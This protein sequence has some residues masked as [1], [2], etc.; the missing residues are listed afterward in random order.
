MSNADLRAVRT[1][2]VSGTGMVGANPLVAAVSRLVP[3]S[4]IQFI[5]LVI[6]TASLSATAGKFIEEIDPEVGPL[7]IP[8][9]ERTDCN[10]VEWHPLTGE[11][12][13]PAQSLWIS[14]F[15][16]LEP[17]LGSWIPLPYLRFLGRGEDGEPRYDKGPSN[18]VRLYLERPPEGLRNVDALKAVVAIDTQVD[19]LSRIDQRNYLLPNSDD[20][21][22]APIFKLV[23]DAA[24]VDAF[25]G[26]D[27][28][29]AW[30]RRLYARAEEGGAKKTAATSDSAQTQPDFT[31]EHVARYLSMLKVLDNAVEMPQLQF[32]DARSTHW[33]TRSSSVDVLLDIDTSETSAAIIPSGEGQSDDPQQEP[34]TLRFRDLSHPTRAHEGSFPT[35]A[36]FCAPDFG[37]EHASLRSGRPD[38]FYWPSL[39]RV[40]AEGLRL[41]H[42][43]GAVPGQTGLAGLIGSLGDTKAHG[44]T[45]RFSAAGAANKFEEPGTMVAG[46]L[47]SHVAED[48]RIITDGAEDLE[49][50]LR[51][52]FSLSAILSMFIAECILH[53]MAQI[54]DC[55]RISTS[56][57]L[58]TLKRVLITCQLSASSEERKQL[59]ARVEQA[60]DQIWT[61]LGWNSDE[62][63]TPNR[64]EVVLSM[65]SDLSSQIVYLHDE[66]Q[67]CYCG[68]VRQFVSLVGRSGLDKRNGGPP[69]LRVATLDLAS[70]ATTLCIIDY[71]M[72]KEGG[73]TPSIEVAD[74]TT[75]AGDSLIEMVVNAHILPAIASALDVAGHAD[76]AALL[77]RAIDASQNDKA[78]L[79]RHF[80]ARF[81]RQVLI[82]AA[83]ALIELHQTVSGR[84]QSAIVRRVSFSHLVRLGGGCMAPL[85]AKLEALAAGENARQFRLADV[86]IAYDAQ[87][88]SRTISQHFSEPVT[89]ASEACHAL[90]ADLML[91]SGRY[92]DLAE[93]SSLIETILPLSPHRIVNM[94][95]H[96]A[97]SGTLA[98]GLVGADPRLAILVGAATCNRGL[99]APLDRIAV[100]AEDLRLASPPPPASAWL[101]GRSADK[102]T[103]SGVGQ[104]KPKMNRAIAHDAAAAAAAA[105]TAT[106]SS[107]AEGAA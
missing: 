92:A 71:S 1:N 53:A 7:L 16:A 70:R 11:P 80:S 49:P 43:S 56:G 102:S 63:L 69:G 107:R 19:T 38:A 32:V 98:S 3:F 2:T 58:R 85:D 28:F 103:A 12:L 23:S 5:D 106:Q 93:V 81:M 55:D 76:G 66:I 87:D 13:V 9:S 8:L 79:A 30:L 36:E 44:D 35:V 20:V 61:A 89:R 47:L 75:V 40:G 74:R 91:L 45:W 100:L 73:L 54:G 37:D 101:S 68:G 10:G 84:R 4:G 41:S 67:H 42:A 17:F 97:A 95:A 83:T 14:G 25:L 6:Q 48:G 26:S 65:D 15:Q 90:R 29:D 88:F 39:V 50:A 18:W 57:H 96:M 59:K 62:V 86:M 52:H 64:P 34:E 105:A 24:N 104:D 82:P 99:G 33:R 78:K 60:L 72:G 51:P 46:P 31:L 21:V 94:N 22:F 27:W 77:I